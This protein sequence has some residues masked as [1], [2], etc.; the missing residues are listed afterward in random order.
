MPFQNIGQRCIGLDLEGLWLG[1]EIQLARGKQNV[2]TFSLEL[3]AVGVPR[4]WVAIKIFVRQKLQAVHKNAGH[5]HI[6]MLARQAH[7]REMS[8]VQIAHGGHK[9]GAAFACQRGAQVCNGVNDLHGL[10]LNFPS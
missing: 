6:A 5:R 10:T 7:Q 9:R 2:A 4:T 1:V 8:I 3:G